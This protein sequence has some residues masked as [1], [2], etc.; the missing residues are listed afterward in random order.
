MSRRKNNRRARQRLKKQRQNEEHEAKLITFLRKCFAAAY[1]RV[2]WLI[3]ALVTVVTLVCGWYAFKSK[4]DVSYGTL[5]DQSNPYSTSFTLTN[6]GLLPL[7]NIEW[8]VELVD[9][10]YP[11]P[12]IFQKNTVRQVERLFTLEPGGKTTQLMSPR[13]IVLSNDLPPKVQKMD[14]LCSVCYQNFFNISGKQD[15]R[16]LC[17]L[18]KE[19]NYQWFPYDSQPAIHSIERQ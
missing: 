8:A 5:V 12:I 1:K 11:P 9:V 2:G 19:G 7:H 16:F 10:Q 3:G 17:F 18:T 6:S 4:I 13:D 15:F 14:V